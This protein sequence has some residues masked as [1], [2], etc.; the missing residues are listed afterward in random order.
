MPP[1]SRASA[2]AA[3]RVRRGSEKASPSP[4]REL[5]KSVKSHGKEKILVVEDSTTIASVVK[6]FLELE[7]FEPEAY[8]CLKVARRPFVW[9]TRV[10][11]L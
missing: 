11:K 10:P 8:A 5:P 6:Y 3:R 9:K 1:A 2:A 4:P 7:G